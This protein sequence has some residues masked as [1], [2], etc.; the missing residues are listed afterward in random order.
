MRNKIRINIGLMAALVAMTGNFACS[1]SSQ[2][3]SAAKVTV[4]PAKTNDQIVEYV[5]KAFNVPSA[6]SV[7]IKEE[8][9]SLIS[10]LNVLKIEFSSERGSQIQ[11]AW[12]TEDHNKLI[13]GRFMDLTVDPYKETWSKISFNNV[14]AKGPAEA[15]VTIVEYTD[16]Q[17][18]YCSKAHLNV[19]ELLNTYD[20]KIRIVY[21]SFPLNIHNWAEDAAIIGTC[22]YQ[23]NPEALWKYADYFFENQKTLTKETLLTD[24]LGKAKEW[25]L[26][27]ASLK[28]CVDAKATLTI[29]QADVKE[30]QALGFSSTPSFVVN[31]RPVVGALP[32]DQFKQVIDEALAAQ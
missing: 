12:I 32:I 17:C 29:V 13:V 4:Q 23:Q 25:N 10:G 5:R 1:D 14:P 28:Q 27:V 3:Q 26:D 16:F 30:A 15:K 8:K 21:K 31:G 19:Q 22:A 24:A 20:G 18:P 7:V 9:P 2:T 6:V 11:E